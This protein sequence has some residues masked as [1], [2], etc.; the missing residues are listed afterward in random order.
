MTDA[1]LAAHKPVSVCGETAGDPRFIPLLVGLGITDLSMNPV[2][3]LEAKKMIR[4]LVYSRWEAI[5]KVVLSLS[6]AE[7]IKR[8]LSLEYDRAAY[9]LPGAPR[10]QEFFD[11]QAVRV[12]LNTK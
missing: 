9:Q 1:A 3:L 10:L 6:S 5:A 12:N 4:S 8:F 11:R 7:E 2:S